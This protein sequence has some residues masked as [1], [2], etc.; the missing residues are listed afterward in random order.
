MI[1]ARIIAPLTP[2]STKSKTTPKRGET[3]A[4]GLPPKT[5]AGRTPGG[6]TPSSRMA[7][8]AK[9]K[10]KRKGLGSSAIKEPLKD[11]TSANIVQ[12]AA[13]KSSSFIKA[14]SPILMN[15]FMA[16]KQRKLFRKGV[17]RGLGGEM[18]KEDIAN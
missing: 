7:M 14:K 13:Q 2:A 3:K 18:D 8:A 10:E 5:P 11:N 1:K 15:A 4:K 6:R 9:L 17:G 12:P 16:S